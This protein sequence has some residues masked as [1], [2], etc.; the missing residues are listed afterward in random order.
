METTLRNVLVAP[1]RTA[2]TIDKI[3]SNLRT[4]QYQMGLG[5]S[6][7]TL[8]FLRDYEKVRKA[9][10]AYTL[11]S[12]KT[13]VGSAAVALEAVGSEVAKVYKQK[14]QE[15]RAT[16]DAEDNSNVPT[17]K[18]EAKMVDYSELVK[19]RD[20]MKQRVD[21]MRSP[22][23]KKEYQDIQSY[24]LLCLA[25]MCHAILRNQE[26]CKMVVIQDWNDSM[27][28][29]R[30]YYLPKYNL[31]Y[32]YE[33]KTAKVYGR[34]TILLTDELNTILR[35]CLALRPYPTESEYLFMI[36]E[37]GG[38]LNTL[39]KLYERAGLPGIS[40]TIIRNIVATYRSGPHLQQVKE[41]MQNSKDF[42]HSVSQ[43][44]RYIRQ[45]KSE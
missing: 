14:L 7:Q 32:I 30:N 1:T 43:H 33:Y 5:T 9:M 28:K 42:G 19:A 40:P 35:N 10:V 21:A 44:L 15:L 36:N 38:K 4:I 23:S 6:L 13:Y 12:Y 26:F 8:D 20:T 11:R 22:V 34:Q 17:A 16:I 18:Q 24:M 41:V 25:T 37:K 3:I 2:K 39:Q 45:K 29:D 27:P 31:M